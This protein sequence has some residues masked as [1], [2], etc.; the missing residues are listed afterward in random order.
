[1][2]QKPYKHNIEY[3]EQYYSYGSE[4]K[5][6]EFKPAF[7]EKK[8]QVPKQEKEPVTTLCIDPIAFCGL[9]VAVVMLV[10]MVLG[11][12]QIKRDWDRYEQVSA[13]VSELKREN[14]RKILVKSEEFN[15]KCNRGAYCFVSESSD[16]FVIARADLEQRGPGDF[17]GDRQ[18]G[19]MVLRT[20]SLTDM[21]LLEETGRAM[22]QILP[23]LHEEPYQKL[24]AEAVRTVKRAGSGKTIH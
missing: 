21:P 1:M 22:E 15:Q 9:M 18:S 2:A 4:A 17:F 5:V 20:A 19:E 7:Q 13:Y 12:V 6:V 14:A 10:T 11:A 3:I 8:V 16:G 23:H 24:F